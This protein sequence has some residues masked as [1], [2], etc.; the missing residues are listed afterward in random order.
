MHSKYAGIHYIVPAFALLTLVLFSPVFY[1]VWFSLFRI[2]YG[3]PTDFAGLDNFRDLLSDPTLPATLHRSA[4][5]TAAAVSITIAL[6]LALAI[7]IHRLGERRGFLVQ[8]IVIVPWIISTVVATLLF[9]WVFVNDIGLAGSIARM[10][11]LDD[12]QMLNNPHSA[13]ALLVAVSVWKRIGYA[14]IILLAGV[15]GIPDDYE[16]AAL[17]DGA[18]PFQIFRRITLPLL[19]TPLLLVAI[20]LTLSNL[21]TVETP[22]VLTGGGPGDATRILPMDVFDRAFITYDLG[23]ATA[24]ALAMFFGNVLLVLAYVRLAKWK[25]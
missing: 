10:A 18:T 12:I 7:W 2:Q 1:G 17:I 16:E 15:K 19:K 6:S 3:S 11:G 24:L 22:L 13:M 23:S 5:F 25:T 14:V 8:I 4:I 20:V 21:N 9:R